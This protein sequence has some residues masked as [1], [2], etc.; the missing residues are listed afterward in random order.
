[1][2]PDTFTPAFRTGF[3]TVTF[4]P[5]SVTL[6][7]Q[8]GNDDDAAD[9]F[10]TITAPADP[11]SRLFGGYIVLTPSDGGTV[12]RVPYGGY[13]GDYQAIV[14]LT[15]TPNGFPWLPARDGGAPLPHPGGG[16]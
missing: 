16:G 10:V 2:G 9:I 13:N 1:T 8:R 3:A 12:L 14:A 6:G 5:S 7:G 15:P 4:S 11:A